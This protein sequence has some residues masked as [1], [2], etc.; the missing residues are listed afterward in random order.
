MEEST[1]RHTHVHARASA[2][3]AFVLHPIPFLD[4]ILI[5]PIH[6]ALCVRVA[7]ARAVPIADLPWE[8]V[9]KVIWYGA[10]ARYVG[11]FTAKLVP[12]LGAVSNPLTAIAL[13][14]YLGH[15][16]DDVISHPDREPPEIT[17]ASMTE[18]MRKAAKRR[19]EAL[20]GSVATPRRRAVAR[21]G[22][23][24]RRQLRRIAARLDLRDTLARAHGR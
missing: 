20:P 17:V 15:Y 4:E 22:M 14:E 5:V 18:L 10:A 9:G 21:E 23:G 16:L 7:R 11:N 2:A 6:Y 8:R 19:P 12:F 1:R 13:T 24:L 3:A